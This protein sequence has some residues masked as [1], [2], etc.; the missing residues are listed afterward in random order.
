V[1][2][3]GDVDSIDGEAVFGGVVTRSETSLVVHPA[4]AVS[5]VAPTCLRVLR[6][7]EGTLERICS[8]I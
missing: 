8:D 1:F 3:R 2:D 5:V 6:R 4:S 7:V